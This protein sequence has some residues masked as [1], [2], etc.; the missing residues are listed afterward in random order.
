LKSLARNT[1]RPPDAGRRFLFRSLLGQKQE[2]KYPSYKTRWNPLNPSITPEST[3][4][5]DR[6]RFGQHLPTLLP[7]FFATSKDGTGM[8]PQIKYFHTACVTD[9]SAKAVL[10]PDAE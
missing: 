4:I 10:L 9:D 2:N 6:N 7:P 3:T 8:D 5:F 1:N